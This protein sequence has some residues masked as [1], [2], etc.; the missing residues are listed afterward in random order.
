MSLPTGIELGVALATLL[1]AGA[2]TV[3]AAISRRSVAEIQTDRDLEQWPHL[4]ISD[5]KP[6]SSA[7]GRTSAA[8]VTNLGRELA[9]NCIFGTSENGA[10]AISDWSLAAPTWRSEPQA[11]Q[12]T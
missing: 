11:A 12:A 8:T 4:P 1:L 2:T 10:L 5:V 6:G 7:G 9:L 3:M